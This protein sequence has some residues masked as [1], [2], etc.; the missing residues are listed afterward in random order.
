MQLVDIRQWQWMLLSLIVGALIGYVRQEAA[1]DLE[2]QYGESINGQ[3]HFEKALLTVEQGRPHFTDISV[4]CRTVPDGRGGSKRVHVVNGLYFNGQYAQEGGRLIARWQPAFFLADIPY[5]PA[6]DFAAMGKPQ[7]AQRF[8]KIAKPTVLDF[9]DLLSDA[10]NVSY[11]NAWW[12]G[13]GL[14]EWTLASFILVGVIWPIT[15]NLLVYGSWHRPREEPGIDLSKVDAHS[16]KSKPPITRADQAQLQALE[17]ELQA[18]LEPAGAPS[19]DAPSSQEPVRQ[20]ETAPLQAAAVV[21]QSDKEF[22]AKPDDF[23]PT[24]R[25]QRR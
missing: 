19:P 1:G 16:E 6:T 10:A 2:S 17:T 12:Q 15:I 5:K 7:L 25:K 3:K 4:H 11:T 24:E 8:Q 20:L 21:D 13:M 14:G 18:Q 22:G 9:L 23:Y